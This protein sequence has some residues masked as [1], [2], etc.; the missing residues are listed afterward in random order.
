MSDS[1]GCPTCGHTIEKV[2]N[3]VFHCGRCGTM[4]VQ[5]AGNSRPDT[6]VPTLVVRCRQL[7][8]AVFDLHALA[9]VRAQWTLLGV[10]ESIHQLEDRP[11]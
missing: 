9:P 2:V 8:P 7:E 1:N 6:Y 10:L 5:Q 11:S 4:T 3:H